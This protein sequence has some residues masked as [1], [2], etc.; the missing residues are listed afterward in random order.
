MLSSVTFTA[1]KL[2]QHDKVKRNK[3]NN[4]DNMR[5]TI[6]WS[7]SVEF[8]PYFK[9]I[10]KIWLI[11][12]HFWIM[13][14]HCA[15]V[16]HYK[17]G[18]TFNFFPQRDDRIPYMNVSIWAQHK[19]KPAMK[20]VRVNGKITEVKQPQDQS[21][22]RMGDHLGSIHFVFFSGRNIRQIRQILLIS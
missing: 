2:S 3:A 13:L 21:N 14:D 18:W 6:T 9:L 20:A 16:S 7:N 1:W 10:S 12:L 5:W 17:D 11:C 8:F 19:H 15:N 4:R 22:S